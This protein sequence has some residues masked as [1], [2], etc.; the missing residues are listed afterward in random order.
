MH[1]SPSPS[2][3]DRS[4]PTGLQ[5][6]WSGTFWLALKSPLQVIIAFWS[7]PLIQH[8]IG[9]ETNGAYVFGW[10]LGFIQ[11]LL[12]FGMGSAL[13]QQVSY[14]W[15]SGD[16]ERV[17]RLVACG[18]TFY[19]AISVLQ[20]II[21]LAIAYFGLPV[22]FQGE[23][24]RLIVGVLWIQALSAPLFGLLSVVSTVLQ[25]AR[26]YDFLPRLDLFIVVL[27]FAILIIG[28]RVGVDF[29]AIVASQTIVLLG[30]MLIPA[31][32]V[33][34]FE[35]RFVPRLTLPARTDFAPL[36]QIGFYIFLM[37]LSVVLADKVDS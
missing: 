14:A 20:M 32:W 21:L 25:A 3:A 33:L 37:Q 15:T 29:L 28:L 36:V 9:P 6:L 16:R 5:R 24:R 23:S 27:R 4:V 1:R 10:G 22:K 30:G 35:L 8:A 11:F 18:A 17:R 26:R 13:Q 19:A 7:V 31:L 12:E 2:S 34:V